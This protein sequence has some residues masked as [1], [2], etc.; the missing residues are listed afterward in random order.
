MYTLEKSRLSDNLSSYYRKRLVGLF[1]AI[2]RVTMEIPSFC[3]SLPFWRVKTPI[4]TNFNRWLKSMSKM[5]ISHEF[6]C[7]RTR[8]LDVQKQANIDHPKR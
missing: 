7:P 5:E 1:L 2:F 4:L 6:G 3:K 8:D